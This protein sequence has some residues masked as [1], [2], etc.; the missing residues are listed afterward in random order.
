MV[1][2][3]PSNV[4]RASRRSRSTCRARDGEGEIWTRAEGELDPRGR[5]DPRRPL[6]L[7]TDPPTIVDAARGNPPRLRGLVVG[8]EEMERGLVTTE[9]VFQ[10]TDLIA[11]G[12]PLFLHLAKAT[13][14]LEQPLGL[15]RREGCLP[16]RMI[17]ERDLEL[18]EAHVALAWRGCGT[19]ERPYGAEESEVRRFTKLNG[20]V[21]G[22]SVAVGF[23]LHGVDISVALATD[24]WSQTSTDT[25]TDTLSWTVYGNSQ[26]VPICYAV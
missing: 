3:R 9:P 11:R 7:L 4:A 26:T 20:Y 2:V 18:Q 24:Q 12:V 10:P 16:L 14:L 22:F 19:P 17:F 23:S 1:R 5:A 8:R 25:T 6:R 15:L 21:K 13:E